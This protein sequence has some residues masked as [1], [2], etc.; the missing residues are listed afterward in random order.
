MQKYGK[1]FF[2]LVITIYSTAETLVSY[3]VVLRPNRDAFLE[4]TKL[5]NK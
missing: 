2:L 3:T 4:E 5:E 1:L